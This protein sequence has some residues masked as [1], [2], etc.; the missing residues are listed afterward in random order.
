MLPTL[1][2]SRSLRLTTLCALYAAQGM[3]DGFVRTG[4]K[5]YLIDRE[6]STAV[7]GGM[8]ALVSWPWALKWLWGPVI[9]RFQ[10]HPMGKRRPWVLA[11]QLGMAATLAGMLFLPNLEESLWWLA[12]A[13]LIANVF[14][15]LQ[16]VSVDALA[17]DLLPAEER[18]VANGFMFAS[19]YLGAF[20]GAS[21][22]GGI[23]LSN[24]LAAAVSLQIVV[25]LL[26]VVFPLLLRE[27][28]GDELLPLSRSDPQAPPRRT[29]PHGTREYVTRLAKAFS[30][31]SSWLAG[32]LAL[33]SLIAVNA[34]LVLWPT[35]LTGQLDWSTEAFLSLEGNDAVWFGLA[36]SVGGGLLA[37][38]F[39][40]RRVIAAATVALA[41]VCFAHAATESMWES[42]RLVTGLF[43]ASSML[44][45]VLQVAMFA[46]FMGLAWPPVAATQF[47]VYMAL[48]NVSNGVGASIAGPLKAAMEM[49]M[50]FVAFGVFQLLTLALIVLID[51]TETRR[52][53]GE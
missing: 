24:G 49:P 44:V 26:I 14:A 32:L 4:L 11:A 15:S 20:V 19:S 2:Q 46:M 52:R 38:A 18:G 45:A 12:A 43:L 33:T 50:L 41:A 1:S 40:A 25:L 35:H 21:V 51:P 34:N 27:R 30:V 16:D 53:L 10:Y 36:G 6:V 37:S 23:L 22:L 47:T 31:R 7:V 9:D 28:P 17:V 39:G 42:K 13:I 3:P 5:L 29:E 8:V 48:L